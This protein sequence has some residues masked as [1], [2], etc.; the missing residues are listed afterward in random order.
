MNADREMLQ[1][2]AVTKALE[3]RIPEWASESTL[4]VRIVDSP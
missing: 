2:G 3:N 1:I 4:G